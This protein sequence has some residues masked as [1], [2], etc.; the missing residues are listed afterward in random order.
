MRFAAAILASVAIHAALAALAVFGLSLSD[1]DDRTN[2]ALD[3]GA[4]EL[5]FA[6]K[7][8]D[9]MPIAPMPP[10]PPPSVAEPMPPPVSHQPPPPPL[11]DDDGLVALPPEVALRTLPEAP[12]PEV[13]FEI[14]EVKAANPEKSA[15][16]VAEPCELFMPLGELVDVD[17]ELKRLAKDLKG[18]EGEIARAEKML[19]NPG[20]VGKAPAQLVE[21]EKEKLATNRG[22]LSK[23]KQGK[24]LAFLYI[25]NNGNGQIPQRIMVPRSHDLTCAPRQALTGFN[26]NGLS[27]GRTSFFF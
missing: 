18:L 21:A 2:I 24:T 19:S 10:A 22:L 8:R 7:E 5:S 12:E 26:H 1:N 3:I 4:V 9:E 13:K 25:V 6:E 23:V 27:V 15:S 16:A 11:L 20:F 14:L 17:K